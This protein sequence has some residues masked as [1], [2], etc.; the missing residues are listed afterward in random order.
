[1]PTARKIDQIGYHGLARKPGLK[2]ALQEASG[3][4]FLH[5]GSLSGPCRSALQRSQGSAGPAC[6]DRLRHHRILGRFK[7]RSRSAG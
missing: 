7:R 4:Y 5:T 3:R 6:R 1:M 2:L